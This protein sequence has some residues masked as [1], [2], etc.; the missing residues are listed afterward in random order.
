MQANQADSNKGTD[1][2]A[3]RGACRVLEDSEGVKLVAAGA[4]EPMA[5]LFRYRLLHREA[6]LMDPPPRY[7][8]AESLRWSHSVALRLLQGA[9]VPQI[10]G[11]G[12]F[13]V[14]GA[15]RAAWHPFPGVD[16]PVLAEV[17]Q[18][19]PDTGGHT[20]PQSDLRAQV[21]REAGAH[22]GEEVK[23]QRTNR[24]KGE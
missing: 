13:L 16:A 5:I 21:L 9:S 2:S 12:W 1:T 10:L 14:G 23:K 15:H 8:L 7:H 6:S 18:G 22:F 17:C 19:M 20:R 24:E 11:A 4:A 3:A